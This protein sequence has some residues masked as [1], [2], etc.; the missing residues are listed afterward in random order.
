MT[1]QRL[2][3]GVGQP[4]FVARHGLH[5]AEQLDAAQRVDALIRE[6]DLRTV[7]IIL[8]DQHGVPRTKWLTADTFRAA[9]R[10][11][12]DFSGAIYSLDTA[13]SVFAPAFAEGG[14]F[15][16]PEFTG[17][18]DLVVVPDPLTFQQLPSDDR[19]A[20][21]ICDPY[22]ATGQPV[23]LDARHLLKT[24][25][26]AADNLGYRF[27]AGLEVEFYVVA[28]AHDT[29]TAD[30]TGMP[31]P[32]PE[33]RPIEPGYQFLS[34]YRQAALRPLLVAMR[35][36]LL[37]AGLPLRTI[38]NEW[39]PGQLEISFE[40]MVGID[41]ADAMVLFRAL[42]KE[43]CQ[44]R[45]LLASFMCWPALPNFFPSGWHLHQSLTDPAGAN[46]FTAPDQVLSETGSA[47]AA[48]LLEHARAMTLLATPTINGLRRFRP[49]SF[50]PDRV[51]WGVENR[52]TLVRVQGAPGDSGTH[53]ELRIGEP[54]ANPYLHLAASLAA[55]LDGIRNRRVPPEMVDSDPYVVEAATLPTEMEEAIALLDASSFYRTEFGDGFV[56]YL[57]M[58]KRAE[59]ARFQQAAVAPGDGVTAWE[60]NEYLET[61]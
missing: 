55:G 5:T 35:D 4:G 33:I 23:P 31:A 43:T 2:D 26:Q 24:Q 20:W 25:L 41:A 36:V 27:V 8:V 34:E 46:V 37:D 56:A 59:L 61:Y 42:V 32:A 6:R 21:V 10:N 51:C 57:T 3:V 15:G 29:L 40:P 49:Y 48:G 28:R 17:F 30:Q 22:F 18:P 39:G 16:I 1:R 50:A 44:A 60:M 9:L 54:A 19:S 11:G 7:R 12:A 38:E 52:G 47:Y 58:M 13:N 53:L 14:G 45:G